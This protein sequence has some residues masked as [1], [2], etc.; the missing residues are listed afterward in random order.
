MLSDQA[1]EDESTGFMLEQETLMHIE[2]ERSTIGGASNP[3]DALEATGKPTFVRSIFLDV[4]KYSLNRSVE[5]QTHIIDA[6][7]QITRDAI[8]EVKIPTKRKIFLPTGDGLCIA[9]IDVIQPFDVHLILALRILEKVSEHNSTM[10]EESRCFEVRVGLNDNI[11]NVIIDING[12]R[13]I[14]GSGITHAQR[15]MDSAGPMQLMLSQQSAE[16]L[17][18]REAYR[19]KFRGKLATIKHGLTVQVYQY[20]DEG[21]PFLNSSYDDPDRRPATKPPDCRQLPLCLVCYL[22]LTRRYMKQ[23]K[24]FLGRDDSSGGGYVMQVIL[25]FAARDYEV[26][27]TGGKFLE[28]KPRYFQKFITQVGFDI[29]GAYE[30]YRKSAFWLCTELSEHLI[31]ELVVEGE[32]FWLFQAESKFLCATDKAFAELKELFPNAYSMIFGDRSG[33]E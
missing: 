14:A 24:M 20:V 25:V 26:L 23:I 33:R 22:F 15:V 3:S 17:R 5:A 28:A 10:A 30:E 8:K 31:R 18:Y 19:D 7:N 1:L 16:T 29:G 21:L 6:L 12:R 4:V 27:L 32:Y 13:N 9:L 2:E 11:D